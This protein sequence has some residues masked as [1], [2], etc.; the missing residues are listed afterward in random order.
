MMYDLVIRNGRV[1][2]PLRNIDSVG[3]VFVKNSKIVPAPPSDDFEAAE[4]V[5]ATGCIVTPGLIDF[6]A[7]LAHRVSESGLNPDVFFLPNG[8]TAAVDGGSAGT[9][10]FEHMV[11]S[12]IA[13]SVITIKSYMLISPPGI[14]TLKYPENYDPKVF[15]LPKMEYLFERYS[16]HIIGLKARVGKT[17]TPGQGF[18]ALKATID[19]SE[20]FGCPAYVHIIGPEESLDNAMPYFRAGDVFAHFY[21]AV[22]PH[23]ILD[24]SGKIRASVRDGRERGVIFDSASGGRGRSLDVAKKAIDQGFYPDIISA[25]NYALVAY[26]KTVFSLLRPMSEYLC[27]GMPLVEVIRA[28]TQTPAK[29]MGMEG[30]IGTLTPGALADVAILKIVEKPVHFDDLMGNT[31][32][33]DRLFVPQMTVKAGRTMYRQIEFM[34]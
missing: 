26:K 9:S 11:H 12:V 10:N 33:A 27:M 3:D 31:F 5:D 13:T 34:F 8:I 18:E 15:D 4:I 28:C 6:H 17:I 22:G 7:H 2:D 20:R 16:E 1:I 14:T 23:S 19:L 25:D 24:E 30:T 21:Q 29:V 32:E